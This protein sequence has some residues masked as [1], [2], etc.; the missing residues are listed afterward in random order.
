MMVF[1]SY[2]SQ[3]HHD[4]AC[5]ILFSY[6]QQRMHHTGRL[7]TA[8]RYCEYIH[9]L[10]VHLH[11]KHSQTAYSLECTLRLRCALAAFHSDI[12]NYG[13]A[14]SE[15]EYGIVKPER[16]AP[17]PAPEACVATDSGCSTQKHTDK[18]PSNHCC[19]DLNLKH[20]S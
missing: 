9:A 13:L 16:T 11:Y 3:T 20:A 1:C 5:Y 10:N 18:K 2:S 17:G 8:S 6:T 12:S 14:H 4:V 19:S 15:W 7:A